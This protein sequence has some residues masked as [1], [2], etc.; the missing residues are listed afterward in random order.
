MVP[1]YP[2]VFTNNNNN[3][4]NNNNLFQ[5]Q[6]PYNTKRCTVHDKAKIINN[7]A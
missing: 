6:G 7:N 4:N 1:Y 2:I 3:N 5:T